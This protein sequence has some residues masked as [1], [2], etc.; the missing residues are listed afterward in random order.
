M[1]PEALAMSAGL[2]DEIEESDATDRFIDPRSVPV[3]FSCLKHMARSALHYFDAVQQDRDDSLAARL[4]AI[5]AGTNA[6]Q[7]GRGAH[8]MIFRQPVVRFDGA[9]RAGKA[10]EV[11]KLAHVGRT[12]LN[13]KEWAICEEIATALHEHPI[14][15]PL[16]FDADSVHEQRIDWEWLGRSCRSTPD[17]RAPGVVI[18]LKTTQ[19]AAPEKFERDAYWRNY[20]AQLAFYGLAYEHT[21]GCKPR[22]SYIIAV[23]SK[24]PY[25][26]TVMRMPQT[27]LDYGERL[28]R[29]W[30][31]KLLVHEQTDLW[32]AYSDSI[33]EMRMPDDSEQTFTINGEEAF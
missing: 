18:D 23:E 19:N 32:P 11:F 21:F 13:A 8:A 25:A 3:R 2:A 31:E 27:A 28:C 5:T 26:V 1:Q 17:A 6:M 10:W 24:R 14:A 15:S 16:L 22:E 12:I 9:K 20:H 30:M 29:A 4:A 33:V 7:V